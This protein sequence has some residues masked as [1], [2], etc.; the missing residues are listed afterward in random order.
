MKG[1]HRAWLAAACF[2]F[3]TFAAGAAAQGGPAACPA[4]ASELPLQALFGDWEARIDG[5]QGVAK[6]K[7]NQHPDYAGVRGTI[8]RDGGAAPATVSQLA[9]DIDDDGMLSLDES[10]DGHAISGVWL[11]ALEPGSCGR[12]FKGVWRDAAN[13]TT[14]PFV[15]NKIDNSA[16]DR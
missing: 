15:L 9:G 7:L 6:V 13:D 5:T 16:T 10:L 4:S 1:L 14:H 2:A 8:T 3:A 11:G 12:T